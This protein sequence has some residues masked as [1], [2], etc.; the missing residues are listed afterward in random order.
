MQYN[1]NTTVKVWIW[2]PRHTSPLT[3]TN[4]FSCVFSCVFVRLRCGGLPGAGTY[5]APS[6][7]LAGCVITSSGVFFHILKKVIKGRK[8]PMGMGPK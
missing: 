2:V 3:H 8:S 1:L 5:V 7:N 4:F 6:L